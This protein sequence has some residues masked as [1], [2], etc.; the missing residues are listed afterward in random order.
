MK[1][2]FPVVARVA[3][4]CCVGSLCLT[5]QAVAADSC[6]NA[7]LRTGA[8][9]ALPDCR[10]YELVTP[11]FKFGANFGP[12]RAADSSHVQFS[13]IGGFN[14]AGDD[15]GTEGSD[16][17]AA[18]GPA[19]WSS[20][21]VDPP[22]AEFENGANLRAA[23]PLEDVSRDFSKE[24][25]VGTP[26]TSKPLDKRLYLRH[27]DGSL[28]EIGPVFPPE[29]IASWTESRGDF[30]GLHYEG[31]SAD[32]SH[33]VFEINAG[34]GATTHFLWPGDT[35]VQNASLYEYVGTGGG[36]PRLVGVDNS[37]LLISQCGTELG[38]KEDL[39]SRDTYNAIS[40]SGGT[41][42]FNVD[43]GGCAVEGVTGGGPPTRELFAR[44]D[45]SK[46][47]AISEPVLPP[48]AACT[49][50]HACFGASLSAGVFQGASEDGKRVFFLTQQPLLN[51]DEDA[52]SDLYMAEIEGTGSNAE[53]GRLVQV[54]RDEHPGQAGEVQGVARVS[55]DGSHAY[56]VARGALTSTPNNLGR[57]PAPGADNLYVYE[58]DPTHP[59]ESR[60][61]FIAVLS[62]AD[63]QDWSVTDV[64]PVQ[65]TPDGRFLLFASR[66]SLTPDCPAA[67][68]IGQQLYRYDSQTGELVRVSI[69]EGGFNQNGTKADFSILKTTDD[70]GRMPARQPP[71]SMS[72][73]GSYVFFSS[74]TGLTPRAINDPTDTI[75]NVY[76][77]HEGHVY[78]ISDGQDR[79]LA[80]G[81]SAVTLVGASRSGGDV[82]FTTADPLVPQD[83]DT[84]VDLY[85]ARIGG[86]ISPPPA[87]T[88]CQGDGCQGPVGSTPN[89][90]APGSASFTG[91]GN[92]TQPT[93]AAPARA[94][95][96][97]RALRACRRVPTRRR[98]RC[99]AAARRRFAELAKVRHRGGRRR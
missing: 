10:A 81:S 23:S 20:V 9:A 21:P 6:P 77:Y 56:F 85:D 96:L 24:L 65:A 30:T 78:L 35:A 58:P 92:V 54:S 47:I 94:T 37:G 11:A 70:S 90:A 74:P 4:S 60:V 44:V 32:L 67:T 1:V 15:Q 43:P 62:G 72:D 57:S 39:S 22:A 61:A 27:Q 13:S 41:I 80:F 25:V 2:S 91:P 53:V 66:N 69:G 17:V 73:D 98:R 89:Q 87:P 88:E 8:S 49:A 19:G 48:G 59:G 63:S 51:G 97:A 40:A 52:G 3:T 26:A 95:G 29:A 68:C 45:G 14:G 42:F 64:R 75:F 7:D 50:G 18:R 34:Q 46:T 76:E 36:A 84:Q 79:H 55:M 99:V 5:G 28:T 33:V 83:G 12:V 16:Y 86:G 82:Y 31:G 93:P 38:S 71:V